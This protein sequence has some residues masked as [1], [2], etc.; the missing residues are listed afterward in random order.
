MSH[1]AAKLLGFPDFIPSFL[2]A[3]GSRMLQGVNYASG[4]AGIA[5]ESGRNQVYI[6]V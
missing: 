1:F 4:A 6:N 3:S 5:S 2:S